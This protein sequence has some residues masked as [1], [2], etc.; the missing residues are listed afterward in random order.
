MK[1]RR[2][3]LIP[4]QFPPHG[5][6]GVL[7]V[8]KFCKYLPEFGWS[9]VVL[10][11]RI[12]PGFDPVDPSLMVD[13]PAA[14]E[15]LRPPLLDIEYLYH[16]LRGLL[17]AG[18]K[19]GSAGT[20]E[21]STSVAPPPTP[22]RGKIWLWNLLTRLPDN[23]W[24]WFA[25][26]VLAGLR[27][28]RACD[29]LV[30]TGPP[31]TPFLVGWALHQLTGVPLALDMR[32]PWSFNPWLPDSP[33]WGRMVHRRLESMCIRSAAAIISSTAEIQDALLERYPRAP[34]DRFVVIPN[35]F[36]AADLPRAASSPS[37]PSPTD[38]MTVAY[39]GSLYR[40][41][42]PGP[43]FDALRILKDEGLGSDR[44]RVEHVGPA[45]VR[46]EAAARAAGVDDMF[47]S[48]GK[49]PYREALMR[50]RCASALLIIGAEDTDQFCVATKT[51]EYLWAQRPILALVPRGPIQRLVEEEGRGRAVNPHDVAAIA[52]SLRTMLREHELGRLAAITP[53]GIDRFDRKSLTRELASVLSRVSAPRASW[54][55][56]NRGRREPQPTSSDAADPNRV[57]RAGH[58]RIV[59][60]AES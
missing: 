53:Q 45:N 46:A 3:M 8:L 42:D 39:F 57:A 38:A 10:S 18:S 36:D 47:V 28:A 22:S 58:Y 32:D 1:H 6:V 20:S 35:G 43:L 24:G 16:Q 13:V 37:V 40:N 17:R 50:M 15:I 2:V 23:R 41:R 30:A 48:V 26:A 9:S 14:T 4:C 34:R 44:L 52:E 25:P 51:Y 7:R 55:T 31:F 21:A 11:H 12:R 33:S 19:A 49:L 5:G 54:H 59:T 56:R 27:H 60:G 29:C